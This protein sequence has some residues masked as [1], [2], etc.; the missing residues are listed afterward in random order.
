[1]ADRPSVGIDS[2]RI[3]VGAIEG[4]GLCCR[5]LG[6]S[7]QVARRLSA[8]RVSR[9]GPAASCAAGHDA[10]GQLGGP[11]VQATRARGRGRQRGHVG[12]E[13]GLVLYRSGDHEVPGHRGVVGLP[14][15]GEITGLYPVVSIGL[16]ITPLLQV[17]TAPLAP[18]QM[19]DASTL[20][21]VLVITALSAA[22]A[23]AALALPATRNSAP[24]S[25]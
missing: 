10:P 12:L 13:R 21:N 15:C 25:R 23:L 20:F 19:G 7:G 2:H 14:D 22:G 16:V 9:L 24:A 8:Q 4:S 11:G 17:V 3:K 5:P 6:G 1:L 18:A